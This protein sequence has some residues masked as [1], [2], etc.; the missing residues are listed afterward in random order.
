MAISRIDQVLD[1]AVGQA[2]NYG[3][4]PHHAVEVVS[5]ND[6]D[7]GVSY[8]A[9]KRH[10][11]VET[12]EHRLNRF[13]LV[14]EA[15]ADRST[16]VTQADHLEDVVVEIEPL[17]AGVVDE[18]MTS[19]TE[20]RCTLPLIQDSPTLRLDACLNP[21]QSGQVSADGPIGILSRHDA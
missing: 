2:P 15:P 6:V 21:T 16:D 14:L 17:V 5:I 20:S 13:T 8:P 10:S 12:I 11:I 7:Q 1:A 18:L 9:Q 4:E 19:G 3:F